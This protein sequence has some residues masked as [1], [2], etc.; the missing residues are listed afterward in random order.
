VPYTATLASSKRIVS[1]LSER[2]RDRL[3]RWIGVLLSA[4]L[5]EGRSPETKQPMPAEAIITQ[6]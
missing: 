4:F 2:P 3:A 6:R 5:E 1:R